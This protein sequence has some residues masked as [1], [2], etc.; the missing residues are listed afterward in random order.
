MI[1]KQ[2][3]FEFMFP[4]K[5]SKALC[6]RGSPPLPSL[7]A[8][9]LE[10]GPGQAPRPLA[11]SGVLGWRRKVLRGW[12]VSSPDEASSRAAGRR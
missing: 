9:L 6:G 10:G 8:R 3:G 5:V 11:H 1:S 12:R 2:P 7:L 4:L